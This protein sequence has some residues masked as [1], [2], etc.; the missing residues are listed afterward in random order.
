MTFQFPGFLWLLPLALLV[1][2]VPRGGVERR[3]G[4]LRTALLA[5][6]VVALARPVLVRATWS[7]HH[8]VVLDRTASALDRAAADQALQRVASRLQ[9]EAVRVLIE[10]GGDPAAAKRVF[11]AMMTMRKIDIAVIEQARRG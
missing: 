9:P 8:V 1:W 7:D 5:A 10:L 4:L 2:F 6:L 3:H 11:D